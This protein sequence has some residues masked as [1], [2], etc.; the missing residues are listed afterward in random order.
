MSYESYDD[1][2]ERLDPDDSFDSSDTDASDVESIT[3]SRD[4]GDET[5]S[6]ESSD[7]EEEEEDDDDDEEEEEDP[8]SEFVQTVFDH[9][10]KNM[11][12][13]VED[14]VERDDMSREQAESEVY[15]QYL[16]R[17]NTRLRG[18]LVKFM[19]HTHQMTRDDTY[20]KI[21]K[22]AQR[23]REDDDMDYEESVTLAAEMRKVLIT[24]TLRQ[25][26]PILSDEE[27][28]EDSYA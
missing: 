17:M 18:L 22:I 24:R 28:M 19:C 27:D 21:V 14:L 1:M 15:E 2:S 25:W 16:S 8:W 20:K 9:Y 3:D 7:G 11:R 12:D 10:D 5:S 26:T 23:L 6:S 13:D 4:T